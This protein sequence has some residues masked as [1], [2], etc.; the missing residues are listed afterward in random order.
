MLK[1][2]ANNDVTKFKAIK[3][4]FSKPVY[5]GQ[6]LQ[7]DMWKNGNRICF[8]CKSVESGDL[9]L[10]GAYIDLFNIDEVKGK[11]S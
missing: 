10:S 5:P 7:T 4:R 3:V 6:T 11:V 9:V 8:Q 1:Q 2:Y